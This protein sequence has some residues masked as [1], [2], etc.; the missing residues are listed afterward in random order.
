MDVYK[1]IIG[2]LKEGVKG[3]FIAEELTKVAKSLAVLNIQM[4]QKQKDALNAIL[5]INIDAQLAIDSSRVVVS[6]LRNICDTL[7]FMLD[8]VPDEAGLKATIETYLGE[9]KLLGPDVD[10]AIEKLITVSAVSVKGINL[11]IRLNIK[12]SQN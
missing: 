3:L 4:E 10:K 5:A 6:K 2:N 11:L 9:T 12:N 8:S 7:I 1:E